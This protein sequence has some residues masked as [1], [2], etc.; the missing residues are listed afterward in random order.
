MNLNVRLKTFLLKMILTRIESQQSNSSNFRASSKTLKIVEF[1]SL[2][3]QTSWNRIKENNQSHLF[4]QRNLSLDYLMK[5]DFSNKTFQ[6]TQSM[7]NH[8]YLNIIDLLGLQINRLRQ[9]RFMIV[10]FQNEINQIVTWF[11]VKTE[12]HQLCPSTNIKRVLKV[13]H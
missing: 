4:Q 2:M 1:Q 5:D 10:E 12:F 13:I 9:S 11:H 8:Y 7:M 6:M 3:H